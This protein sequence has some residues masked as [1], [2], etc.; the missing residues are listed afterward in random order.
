MADAS[1]SEPGRPAEPPPERRPE[2]APEAAPGRQQPPPR[3][4]LGQTWRR[5]GLEQRAAGA[6]ALLLVV[7]TLGPFSFVEAAI[8]VTGAA[9]LFLLRKR[10]EGREFHVPFGDGAVIAAAGAWSG[11]LIV[12]R[13]F[14]RPLGQ[15]LLALACAALLVLAGLRERSRRPADDLPGE[16]RDAG[17]GGSAAPAPREPAPPAPEASE[18][19]TRRLPARVLPPR[20]REQPP[21]WDEPE[22]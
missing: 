20:D 5:L 2:P 22:R 16:A 10:A 9:V 17:S 21:L 12:V 1:R 15:G 18:D 19:E 13:L 3:L 11:F 7:S 6:A 14:D 8:A 4:T